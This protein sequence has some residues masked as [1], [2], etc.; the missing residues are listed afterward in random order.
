MPGYEGMFRADSRQISWAT[1]LERFQ[2]CRNY[3]LSTVRPDGRPHTM[4]VW[5]T[6]FEGGFYF[7]TAPSSRKARNLAANP[8]CTVSTDQAAEAVIMEGSAAPE[9]DT[10]LIRRFLHDYEAKYDWKM[11]ANDGSYLKLTPAVAFAFTEGAA[12]GGENNPTRFI[13]GA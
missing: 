4:P 11:D 8:H 9:A 13:F 7:S 1:A 2:S 12:A 6:W 5:G 3:W 10:E